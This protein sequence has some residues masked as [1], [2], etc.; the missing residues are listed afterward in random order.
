MHVSIGVQGHARGAE[1]E[2]GRETAN[3]QEETITRNST[4]HTESL[5]VHTLYMCWSHP[6]FQQFSKYCFHPNF[7]H[8]K[9]SCSD[10][11]TR[12]TFSVSKSWSL[13]VH[14]HLY[15]LPIQSPGFETLHNS[16]CHFWYW[17]KTKMYNRRMSGW[18]VGGSVSQ[19]S[20][21]WFQ[22]MSQSQGCGIQPQVGLPT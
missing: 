7:T 5:K 2:E 3:V 6:I 16:T 11:L 1:M 21:C 8:D 18:V 22:L 13:E 12:L 14:N 9:V 19:V 15:P 17:T 20:N 10:R 4:G